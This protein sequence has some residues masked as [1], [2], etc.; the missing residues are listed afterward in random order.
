[1]TDADG[2]I[3]D[4]DIEAVIA[5]T[6]EFVTVRADGDGWV[7]GAPAWF[8]ERL[9]GGF[10]VAQAV[11][12]ATRTAPEGRRIH[13]LHGYFLRPGDAK[14]P[15][16]YIVER[17]RDGGSFATRRVNAVQHGKTIFSMSPSASVT[18]TGA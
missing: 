3:E 10:V 8:G 15:A 18:R 5:E 11:H 13:S 1:M 16:V 17:L 6:I 9:F 7:G 12:A 14:A 4:G 2:D